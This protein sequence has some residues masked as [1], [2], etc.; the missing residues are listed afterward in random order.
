VITSP[1]YPNRF[2][3][4]RETRPHLF[5]FNFVT[6]ASAVGDLETVAIGG[7]WGKATSILAGGITPANDLI[8]SLLSPYTRRINGEC[9]LMANYVTKY[10]ND[11]YIHAEE[12]AKVCKRRVK[13]AYVIGNSKFFGHP[14]PSDEILASIFAHFGFDL[15]TIERMRRRQSKAG[16]YEAVVFMSRS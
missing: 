15:E 10:F 5:F 11:M 8:D 9:K 6:G 3:Y 13:L 16:L 1:P 14:L 4:A 12:V 7:T 2:S